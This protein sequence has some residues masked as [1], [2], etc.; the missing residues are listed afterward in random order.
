VAFFLAGAFPLFNADAYGHLAQGRQIVAL[1][2]VPKV[3][4]FSFWKP[5]PQPWSNYEWGYDWLS[6]LAYDH[7]GA[8][9]LVLA[10]CF[11]LALLGYLLVALA[12]RLAREAESAGPLALTALLLALP[13]ARFRF[14][15]R[16]Q[17]VGLVFPAIL[18]IGIS[19]LYSDSTSL[20]RRQWT[21]AGLGAL[22]VLWVN[23]HG[24]HLFGVVIAVLFTVFAAR[25]AALRWMLGLVGLQLAATACTP[26]GL[27]IATDAV[28]HVLR[29]EYREL[30]VEWAA[31]SPKDPLRLLVAP[32]VM[33]SSVLVAVRPVARESRYGL[34]YA[35]LC[36]VLSIMAFRSMRFVAHQ[37]LF[38]APFVAAGLAQLPAFGALRR[39]G[40]ALVGA[41]AL[42]SVLWT[43]QLVP[44][45]GFG[46]GEPKREYPWASAEIIERAV[47]NPRLVASLQDSWVLMFAAPSAKLLIDGRVPFYGPDMIRRV[48][49]SF[50][51]QAG[52]ARQLAAY[53]VN[54]VVIDHTRADHIAATDYLSAQ[55]DWGL[56]FVED[57]HSL[58]V[59][60]DAMIGIEPF[61]ILAA[62]YRTGGLLDA[63]FADAEIR[64]EATRLNA[65]A[66]TTVMQ[67]W[68]Q[69]IE[70]LRPLARD[71]SRAG[72]RKY[73]TAGEQRI[74]RASYARLSFAA[75]SFPGFTTIE[76]YRAMAALAACDL[77]EARAALGRAMYGGQTRETSLVSL[78]LS[79]RSG[80]DAEGARARTHLGRLLDAADSRL[81]PWV[82]AIAADLRVRCP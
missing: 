71:G 47:Q 65:K 44:A 9:A 48:A 18:L 41:A 76:L 17:I 70:L 25:T 59:R 14:T 21:L 75:Q 35:A 50:A 56:V 42:S 23:M 52:F 46:F 30:V 8:S 20:R 27:G 11:A 32:I 58:F 68:H 34:A 45:L 2:R 54:T 12:F 1:G 77:P 7:L 15:V 37:L 5:E 3:D 10:K 28:A 66:N 19:T 16:P 67:A 78:E 33:A 69:G 72:I 26:F 74:A 81:D 82:R 38:C 39:G 63:R 79:L 13:V 64:E 22:H 57:G 29:P 31:W 6:W 4:L 55:D 61:R 73:A 49:Q 53:D 60:T 40:L 80:D 62:G 43:T 51:D 24:S 36:V